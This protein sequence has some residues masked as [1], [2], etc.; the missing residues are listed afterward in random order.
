MARYV[1]TRSLV[2][3]IIALF[4]GGAI[5]PFPCR[6]CGKMFYVFRKNGLFR[7]GKGRQTILCDDCNPKKK[8]PPEQMVLPL[9]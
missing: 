2:W 9:V 1:K 6:G 5:K 4:S 7:T 3:K 8:N